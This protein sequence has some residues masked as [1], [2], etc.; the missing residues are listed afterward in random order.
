[1]DSPKCLECFK[2][3]FIGQTFKIA[4]RGL[5]KC[6]DCGKLYHQA[7]FQPI[8]FVWKSDPETWNEWVTSQ[9]IK[10]KDKVKT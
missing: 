10:I 8:E 7:E 2:K 6:H 1:M 9:G 5:Y 4:G 3:G